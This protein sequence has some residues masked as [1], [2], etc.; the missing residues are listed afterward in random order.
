MAKQHQVKHP[1][2]VVT[3]MRVAYGAGMSTDNARIYIDSGIPKTLKVDG[4]QVDVHFAI[5]VHESVEHILMDHLGFAYGGAFGAHLLA[6]G[7]EHAYLK[8]LGVDPASYERAL[9]P[10]LDAADAYVRTGKAKPDE[11]PDDLDLTPYSDSKDL[12]MV[13]ILQKLQED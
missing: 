12:S 3:S 8:S 5:E 7:V 11:V 1:A 13:R 4:V 2:K 9:G 10:Y 6:E